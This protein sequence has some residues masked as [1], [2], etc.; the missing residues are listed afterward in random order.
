MYSRAV[1]AFYHQSGDSHPPDVVGGVHISGMHPLGYLLKRKFG[2][3]AQKIK[4]LKAAMVGK[5]FNNALHPPVIC[6]GSICHTPELSTAF[7]KKLD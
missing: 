7:C 1:I 2:L 6:V 3:F 5:A 4:N